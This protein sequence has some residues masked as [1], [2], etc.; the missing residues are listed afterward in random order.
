MSKN[1]KMQYNAGGIWLSRKWVIQVL[2]LLISLWIISPAGLEAEEGRGYM[3]MDAGYNTGDFG[4]STRSD[5]YYINAVFG[6]VFPRYDVSVSIPYLFLNEEDEQTDNANGIGDIILRGGMLFV[7][8]TESGF[9]C[10][11]SLAV[12]FPT[13]DESEGLGTG[14]LDYGAFAGISQR[15]EEIKLSL[16]GGLIKIGDPDSQ[17]YDD[18]Y[19]YGFG[20]SRI[21]GDTNI[22]ASFEGR[23]AIIPDADNPQEIHLGF[24]HLLNTQYSLKGNIFGGLNDGGPDFGLSLGVVRW[25]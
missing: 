6:Y 25:F 13:A 11:G 7:P 9:S 20:I 22:Y 1:K 12:K 19:F 8:E 2:L 24:F 5:L 23:R 3:E 18:S 4:T 15:I 16:R 17:D 10:D 21:F 14:E